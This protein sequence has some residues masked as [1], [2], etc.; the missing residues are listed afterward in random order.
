MHNTTSASLR[1]TDFSGVALASEANYRALGRIM[2]ALL[3][4]A[5]LASYISDLSF[6]QID[7]TKVEGAKD[8][9]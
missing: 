3:L 1:T 5:D 6:G 8:L 2:S 7:N 4:K 9:F